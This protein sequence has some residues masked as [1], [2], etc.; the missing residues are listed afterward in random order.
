MIKRDPQE[1]QRLGMVSKITWGVYQKV[2]ALILT[3]SKTWILKLSPKSF[4][5]AALHLYCHSLAVYVD[6][7]EQ[8]T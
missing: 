4:I 2:Q 8:Y 1:K 6:D 7:F 3:I 5:N